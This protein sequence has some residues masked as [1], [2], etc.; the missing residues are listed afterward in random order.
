MVFKV[1]SQLLGSLVCLCL[2]SWGFA[3]EA[4]WLVRVHV[5]DFR[6]TPI[7]LYVCMCLNSL[8]FLGEA[9]WLVRVRL[10]EFLRR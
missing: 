10:F 2:N 6:E 5:F 1:L 7:R 8:G 3:G 4:F 9:F